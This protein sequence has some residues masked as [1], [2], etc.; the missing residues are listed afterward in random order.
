MSAL[1]GQREAL[2]R[3]R[4]HYDFPGARGAHRQTSHGPLER[5]V[6]WRHRLLNLD[7]F[8]AEYIRAS[9]EE[10]NFFVGS[11]HQ[12][13]DC[14][15]RDRKDYSA[16]QVPCGLSITKLKKSHIDSFTAFGNG[17]RR[18]IIG[19]LPTTP[20]RDY[21]E[22]VLREVDRGNNRVSASGVARALAG[23]VRGE[24]L[25]TA[26]HVI[27]RFLRGEMGPHGCRKNGDWSG[28]LDRIG[29]GFGGS[30]HGQS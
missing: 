11:G 16:Q 20:W 13:R 4:G 30:E 2:A 26:I 6:R 24:V 18:H 28:R 23:P 29:S 10:S 8:F 9:T 22:H 14:R 19:L 17:G 1:S 3:R 15:L 7:G 27:Q 21:D 25:W 5:I 12:Y